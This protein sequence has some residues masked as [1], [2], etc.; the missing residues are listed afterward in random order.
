MGILY[1]IWESVLS[2][3]TDIFSQYLVDGRSKT[4]FDRD[5]TK[6]TDHLDRKHFDRYFEP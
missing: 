5:K 6:L 4:D 2:K 3:T 1:Q